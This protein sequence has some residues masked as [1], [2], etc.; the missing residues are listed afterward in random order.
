MY[1][2]IVF[3]LV[4]VFK[5]I[6]LLVELEINMFCLYPWNVHVFC[7]IWLLVD[8]KYRGLS[9]YRDDFRG[10]LLYLMLPLEM[11]FF[12]FNSEI[13]QFLFVAF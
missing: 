1:I 9:I 5:V 2:S 4:Y 12:L 7:F 11:S 3:V 8:L 10:T 13:Y 6:W